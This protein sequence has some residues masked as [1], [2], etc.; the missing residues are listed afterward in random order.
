MTEQLPLM[1]GV[2][3]PGIGWLRGEESRALMFTE[4][5]VAQETARRVGQKAK[6]YFVDGSLVDIE[7]KL[8]EAER[9]PV[10]IF[11]Q[12]KKA[13]ESKEKS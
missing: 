4:K 5:V 1:Y 7:Q 10:N 9:H 6:V 13:I 2:W 8:L 12:W 11:E 3:L